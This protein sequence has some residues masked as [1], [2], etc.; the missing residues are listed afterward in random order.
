MIID[1]RN[2]DMSLSEAIFMAKEGDIIQLDDKEYFEQIELN[3]KNI[4]LKGN[5]NTVI[6]FDAYASCINP[7]TSKKYGTS[8]SATFR[9]KAGAINFKAYNITF[10]NSHIK[11]TN[12]GEQAVAFKS[13]ASNTLLVNCKFISF[14]DTLYMDDGTNNLIINSYIEGDVDFIFGSSDTVF[15][16]CIIN[17]FTQHQSAYFLAPD[18]YCQNSHGLVFKDCEFRSNVVKTILARRWF[19]KGA[20]SPVLPRIS[21]IDSKFLGDIELDVIIMHEGNPKIDVTNFKNITLNGND[22]PDKGIDETNYVDYI[23]NKYKTLIELV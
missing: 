17:S 10:K 22:V 23:L 21:I 4:T 6:A 7:N 2:K 12:D 18:T 19:P 8:G 13:E 20:I 5:K 16:N 15:K 3:K 14:Q 9:V 11:M 1:M